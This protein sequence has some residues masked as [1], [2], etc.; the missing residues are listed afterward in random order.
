VL[1]PRCFDGGAHRGPGGEAVI[2]KNDGPAAQIRR[3]ASAPE[4]ALMSRQFLLLLCRNGI[5]DTVRDA[6]TL[7]DL[8]VEQAHAAARDSP[9]RQLLIAGDAEFAHEKDVERRAQSGGHFIPDR[10][11]AAWQREDE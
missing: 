1:L 5:D 8:V 9:H 11:A 2:D 10:H 6:H 3:P 4:E 7:D